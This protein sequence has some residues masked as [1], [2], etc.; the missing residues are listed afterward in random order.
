[1]KKEIN[2]EICTEVLSLAGNIT[3]SMVPDWYEGTYRDLKMHL[4][5]PKHRENHRRQPCFLF[6]CGGAYAVVNG[7]IWLPEMMDFARAGYTVATIEYRTSNHDPFPAQLIDAKSAVR[8]LKAHAD[9][10]CIDPEKIVAAGE[11]AGGTLCSLLG[12]TPRLREYD[13][14]AHLEYDSSVAAVVDFYGLVDMTKASAETP[15]QGVVQSWALNA[16]LGDS[17]SRETARQASVLEY[18]TP[19]AP[20]FMILH[21]MQDTVVNIETQSDVLYKRLV[22]NKVY[23]EYL[24]LKDAGH[25]DDAFYQAEIKQQVLAFLQKVLA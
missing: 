19:E 6:I 5:L 9:Q 4:I 3:Y 18:I 24:R 2:A 20:P 14:G 13:Q 25:G 10:F 23:T 21:G 15:G 7:A 8:F 1:M 22:E 12:V 16:F 11:S 17:Y